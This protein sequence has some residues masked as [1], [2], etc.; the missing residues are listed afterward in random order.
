[1]TA[2]SPYRDFNILELDPVQEVAGSNI[3]R[4]KG[5]KLPLYPE[6][7][8]TFFPTVFAIIECFL[9]LCREHQKFGVVESDNIAVIFKHHEPDEWDAMYVPYNNPICK[10]IRVPITG[11]SLLN[12]IKWLATSLLPLSSTNQTIIDCLIANLKFNALTKDFCIQCIFRHSRGLGLALERFLKT[13]LYHIVAYGRFDYKDYFQPITVFQ[14]GMCLRFRRVHW[15][16]KGKMFKHACVNK[17]GIREEPFFSIPSV[18]LSD[19]PLAPPHGY[20]VEPNV[21]FL[22]SLDS[23]SHIFAMSTCKCYSGKPRLIRA[24]INLIRHDTRNKS[25]SISLSQWAREESDYSDPIWNWSL[26]GPQTYDRAIH[27]LA[28]SQ[29][30][31]KIC[32]R[33]Y[34]LIS[35][36]NIQVPPSTWLLMADIPLSLQ[37]SSVD[38][39]LSLHDYVIGDVSFVL[40]FILLF[41][42]NNGNFT[43]LNLVDNEWYFFDDLAGGAFKK[44]DPSRVNYKTKVNLRAFY[45]RKTETKPHICIQEA[46]RA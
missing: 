5:R 39:F 9:P 15:S 27:S 33:C 42:V 6:T 23:I 44:C 14:K 2:R 32:S 18:I 26:F 35:V 8:V 43:S 3:I 45:I 37:K 13:L 11:D 40:K 16:E 4:K 12:G 10:P 31:S 24:F 21:F 1:M 19:F 28:L 34:S 46:A 36:K 22:R 41:N 38:V 7:Q 25:L 30:I 29:P 20:Y 17:N